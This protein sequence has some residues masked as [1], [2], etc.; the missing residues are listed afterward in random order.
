MPTFFLIFS[1]GTP[2]VSSSTTKKL[3]VKIGEDIVLD[4]RTTDPKIKVK[5]YKEDNEVG[6]LWQLTL[7][8]F[9]IL[10]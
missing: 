1:D 2:F 9:Q 10:G 5:V 6:D 8:K 4:C 7:K 3:T